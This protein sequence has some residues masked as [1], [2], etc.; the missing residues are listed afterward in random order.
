[1]H[2]MTRAVC[3]LGAVAFLACGT[4][5]EQVESHRAKA[6]EYIEAEQ[7]SEAK[8]ELINLRNARP[9][10]GEAHFLLGDVHFNLDEFREG[11]SEL[12][13]AVRIEPD[14]TEWRMRLAQAMFAFRLYDD[15]R[16]NVDRVLEVEPRNIDALLLRAGLHSIKGDNDA[17]L[18]DVDK[19]LEIDPKHKGAL[20]F[21]AQVLGRKGDLAGAEE[22]LRKLLEVDPTTANHMEMARFLATLGRHPEALE[23][24]RK[25]IDVAKDAEEKVRAQLN[26]ANLHLNLGEIDKTFEVL[27]TAREEDP[28]NADLL[29]SLARLHHANREPEKAESL[30]Q[31]HVKA[32]ADKPEPLLVLADYYRVL[33]QNEKAIEAID[34]ALEIAPG[35]EPALLRRA[36]YLHDGPKSTEQTR[37]ESWDIVE[38][39][40]QK[41]PR[42]S[43]GHFTEGKFHL[44]EGDFEK[45]TNS[46]RRVLDEQPSANAH[47]LLGN[48]YQR[49]NQPDLARSEFQSALALDAQ[50][51]H[52]RVSLAG[53]HLATSENELAVREART[54]LRLSPGDARARMILATALN[55]LD[56]QAQAREALEPLADGKTLPGEM[57]FQLAQLWR[58][59]NDV[60][61]ARRILDELIDDPTLRTNVQGELISCDVQTRKPNDALARLDGWIAQEP[62]K[63]ELY[64]FRARVRLTLTGAAG[65]PANPDEIEKDLRAAIDKGLE[66][67]QAHMVLAGFYV[68]TERFE[69]A[70]AM[71]QT[72]R[73]RA[74]N[75]TDVPF[76]LAAL[77][78]RRGRLDEAREMYEEVL[79]L[80][81][82][83]PEVK[84]NLAW[85][86]ANA[87]SP[88]EADL[89]R[90][91]E[92]AQSA[93]EALPNNPS[94]ADTLGWVMLKKKVC[95][96][97]TSLFHEAIAAYPESHPLR[98]TVRYHL[99][100]SYECDGEV[101][102]AIS[103]LTRALEE[104][105]SFAER[106]E[107]EAM[108]AR[109]RGR[110]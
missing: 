18:A 13:E 49:M 22:Y 11:L 107:A 59:A 75:E 97:A 9:E 34:R 47:V 10:D 31:E 24:S 27:Q 54:A 90:A 101:D 58:G 5:D 45:A 102:R 20:A 64:L 84:N 50:N 96:A 88:S 8:I 93:K 72:A 109:L 14:R 4:S 19:A 61:T 67:I 41:N 52:A 7:W 76:Q 30:L 104:V 65:K 32:N 100:H 39:V 21:K 98:G 110:G 23:E 62:D 74:P 106:R 48:S 79:R 46:L 57:R 56:Q 28:T 87:P 89:D 33:E 99:A 85:L 83:Q 43:L 78:E 29:L 3:L 77:F 73:K 91:L 95:S 81:Q 53:L 38:N 103:E 36:E 82:D 16:Q 17:M 71:L 68:Q 26:L 105:P 44:L 12:R 70:I 51:L 55:K 37:K 25:A 94:V 35:N 86:L 6:K 42:S 1:M 15:A 40:L 69:E 2:R 92:L 108:L 66:G 63:P 80:N 60:P